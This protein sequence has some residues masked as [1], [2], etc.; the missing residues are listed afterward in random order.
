MQRKRGKMM[1][2]K[3]IN[4]IALYTQAGYTK[5]R[6]IKRLL[7][8]LNYHQIKQILIR[9]VYAIIMHIK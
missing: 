6:L 7:L 5:I 1:N 8:C 4:S 2:I 3:S 9:L